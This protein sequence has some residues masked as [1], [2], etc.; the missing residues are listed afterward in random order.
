MELVVLDA[1]MKRVGHDLPIQE[2]FDVIT[3]TST[4]ASSEPASYNTLTKAGG[5]IA[6]GIFKKKWIIAKPT[7]NFEELVKCAFATRGFLR[8]WIELPGDYLCAQLICKSLVKSE[9][10][11]S[12]LCTA[13]DGRTLL[14]GPPS[15]H[16]SDINKTAVTAVGDEDQKSVQ[17]C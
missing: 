10:I 15:G 8:P 5:I 9:G 14:F 4:G 1:I 7:Q 2:L 13:F 16:E 3:G 6:L 12:A 11:Q 17:S